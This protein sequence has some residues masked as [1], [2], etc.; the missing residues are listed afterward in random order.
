MTTV[1]VSNYAEQ[2]GSRHVIGGSLDILSGGDLDIESGG[3]LKIAGTAITSTA[4]ELNLNDASSQIETITEAGAIAV[5]KKV[6]NFDSTGGTFA[7]TLAAPDASMVGQLKVITMTVDNG[8]VTI[9]L[10]NVEG[11]SAA[12]TA[13]F[14]AVGESLTLMGGQNSKWIVIKEFGVTLS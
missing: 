11:G 3:A 12:T 1:N 9:A 14:D 8:D 7:A 4:A 13:T 6:T 2:G 5:N 10:T